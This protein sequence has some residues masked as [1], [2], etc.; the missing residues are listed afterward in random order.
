MTEKCDKYAKRTQKKKEAI[1]E[2]ALYYFRKDGFTATSIR[3]IAAKAQ[4]SQVS[5][6][7]YFGGK[8]ALVLECASRLMQGVID[9]A[10]KLLDTDMPFLD[11]L[12]AALSLC[13]GD[14][15]R[16][17]Y[18]YFSD[19]ARTDANLMKL[20]SDGLAQVQQDMYRRYI[21]AGKKEGYIKA[22][23]P[24]PLILK[25]VMAFHAIQISPEDYAEE[26]PVLRDLFLNGILLKK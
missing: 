3:D 24:T 18:D 19:S 7:N 16:S 9:D 17:L 10:L 21:E 22:S 26:L 6:Y 2:A 4:V 25:Y 20:L 12:N 14:L 5:I 15:D 1:I 13:T 23:Y 11:K 8:D